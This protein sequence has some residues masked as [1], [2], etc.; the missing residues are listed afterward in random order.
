MNLGKTSRIRNTAMETQRVLHSVLQLCPLFPVYLNSF[1]SNRESCGLCGFLSP[2]NTEIQRKPDGSTFTDI[3]AKDF[4][5][6]NV[7]SV[8]EINGNWTPEASTP[9]TESPV[10]EQLPIQE[11]AVEADDSE[12]ELGSM[13]LRKVDEIPAKLEE[14]SVDDGVFFYFTS[15][16]TGGGVQCTGAVQCTA[17]IINDRWIISAAHCYDDFG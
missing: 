11:P 14:E 1:F 17:T 3:E 16:K 8:K 13:D 7:K 6:G 9:S 15:N 4:R 5:C 10:A 12:N 2:F